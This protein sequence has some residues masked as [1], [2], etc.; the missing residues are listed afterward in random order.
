[1]DQSKRNDYKQKLL[2]LIPPFP[3]SI[4]NLALRTEL[5]KHIE[6]G[7]DQLEDSEYW[8][9]RDSLIDDG[10]I[11]AGRGQGGSAHRVA[12]AE[13][14]PKAA[15]AAAEPAAA[16][17]VP[18]KPESALYEPFHKAIGVGYVQDY[19]IKEFVSEIT[20][21]QGR[22]ATGGR[23][24]RPDV[25]LIAVRKYSFTPGK[26]LEVITFE[27][28]PN[29]DSA[30][31][32]VFEAL[33]HSAV[34]HRSYLAVDVSS[35]DKEIPDERIVQECSRLGVG[36]ITFEDPANYETFDIVTPAKLNEPDPNDVDTFIKNQINPE[37]QE[38]LR[39][40]LQ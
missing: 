4:S 31:E 15:E 10:L 5:R 20:A 35:Y 40:W 23:W 21:A 2:S 24:T 26:R 25:T 33:A 17:V 12:P 13:Q 6:D 7:G 27:L 16:I 36:Y 39:Y 28:K 19:R 37:N 30:L 14:E 32:G 34:A 9:L 8:L 11:E 3:Q 18:V 1:L 22:R 29:V 38:R